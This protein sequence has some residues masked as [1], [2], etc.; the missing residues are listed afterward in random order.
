[1]S[2]IILLAKFMAF[3]YGLHELLVRVVKTPAHLQKID[4]SKKRKKE[5]YRYIS[6]IVALVHAPVACFIAAKLLLKDPKVFNEEH[7]PDYIWSICVSPLNL[8]KRI[9]EFL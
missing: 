9:H 5:Y 1:M 7:G 2:Q 6:D 8:S 3:W 4:D